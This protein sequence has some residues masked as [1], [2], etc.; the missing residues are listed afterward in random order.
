MRIG[1]LAAA[2][3]Q[4]KGYA[5]EEQHIYRHDRGAGAFTQKN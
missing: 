4:M 2:N 3:V 5:D 1:Y